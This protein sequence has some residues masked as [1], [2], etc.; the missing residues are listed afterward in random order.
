M[1]SLL[2]P[3]S[4]LLSHHHGNA[5]ATP[6]NATTATHN[7]AT[8][9]IDATRATRYHG[10]LPT[11]TTAT[12]NGTL[13]SQ[14][15]RTE[16]CYHATEAANAPTPII[17]YRTTSLWCPALKQRHKPESIRSLPIDF[18]T[19]AEDDHELRRH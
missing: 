2:P 8:T 16:R 17:D 19:Q 1:Q 9:V 15:Y 5:T 12:L 18:A 10:L 3:S 11:A 4:P 14:Y 13:H 7:N 6:L